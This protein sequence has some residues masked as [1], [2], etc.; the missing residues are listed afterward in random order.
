MSKKCYICIVMIVGFLIASAVTCAIAEEEPL[1]PEEIAK[2]WKER[3]SEA[4][5]RLDSLVEKDDIRPKYQ[6]LLESAFAA[7]ATSDKP[8][9]SDFVHVTENGYDIYK[10]ILN[11]GGNS[12]SSSG[13]DEAG[14]F[15]INYIYDHRTGEFMG[16][17]IEQL[18]QGWFIHATPKLPD[19]IALNVNDN[20]ILIIFDMKYPE[21]STVDSF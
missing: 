2:V 12:K 18:P 1:S 10:I 14:L 15:I 16:V 11:K 4:L 5:S 8:K 9:I 20:N 6:Y 7:H 3:G 13:E 19:T 17:N 21:D